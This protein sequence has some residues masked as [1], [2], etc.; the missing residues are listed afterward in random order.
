MKYKKPL[1]KLEIKGKTYFVTFATWDR[2]E[3]TPEARKL[4][5]DTCLFFQDNRYHLFAAV[6]MPDHVHLLIKPFP[7]NDT[8]Y[9]TIGSILHSIKS[10]S[11]KQIP[12]VM[13]HLGKVWQDGRHDVMMRNREQFINT[14]DYIRQN[15]VKA[16]LS[17][18]PE[19]YPF[20][21]EDF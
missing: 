12:T 7:K 19:S 2:L 4:V 14:W 5:L 16:E 13:K 20:L 1:P 10:Y 3:L 17:L 9:W 11:A 15:P 18:T 6:I 8:E 21:W